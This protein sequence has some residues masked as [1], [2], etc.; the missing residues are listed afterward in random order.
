VSSELDDIRAR[1]ARVADPISVLVGLFA[2]APV[3]FQIYHAN[4]HCLV[5][6][7]AFRDI[8]GGEPSPDY[9]VLEDQQLE[10]GI[11]E[12]TRRVFI[13][14]AFTTPPVW[15]DSRQAPVTNG[16]GRRCAVSCTGFP[17]F[18]ADGRIGHV[19]LMFK[20]LTA[21][22]TAREA[23]QAERD[24]LR[25]TQ[26]RLQAFLDHAPAVVFVKNLEGR[27]QMLSREAERVMGVD[28]ATALGKTARELFGAA[29][30]AL[31][32]AND[33][34]VTDERTPVQAVE[35][36]PTALGIRHFLMTRFPILGADGAVTGSG[37]IA[38]DVS[39]HKQRE[40]LLQKSEQL[41][42][43]VF[44]SLPMPAQLARMSD[45]RFIDVNQAWERLTG[46]TR[47]EHVGR[48][49]L[50]L[51]LW[52]EPLQRT[53]LL[54]KLEPVSSVHEFPARL[55]TRSGTVRE[56][57]LSVELLE[58]GGEACALMLAQDVTEVRRLER[59][60]RHSQQM[61]AVGRLAGG[62]A[63][64]FNNILTA[65]GGANT[66]LLDELGA[67][68]PR[69]RFA[70]QIQRSANRAATL[71]RQLLTFTRKQPLEPTVLDPNDGVRATA[72][73]LPR[74]IGADIELRT[75]LLAR[76]RV[77]AD[78][79]AIE[80]VLLNLAVNARDAMPAGG[81]L[82]LR[83]ADVERRD[84]I[85]EGPEGAWVRITVS[86]TGVGMDAQTRAHLFEPFF[87]TK[88]QGKGTGLGLS[89]VYGTIAQCGGHI[90][91]DSEPGRG[92][93]FEIYLP[94]DEAPLA[95]PPPPPVAE[96]LPGGRETIL[97]VE[98]DDAVRDFVR[99][100]L[101]TLGYHVLEAADGAQALN[102][103]GAYDGRIDLLLSDVVM[104]KMNGV[105]LARRLAQARP[106]I[107]VIHMSGYAGEAVPGGHAPLINKPFE[108]EV[109]A[110]RV[111]A[112]L[113][114][115]G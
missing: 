26:S 19:A 3:G 70:E 96:A 14:E 10:G 57:L 54:A 51:G 9:N 91:V 102:V 42:S 74:M 76:G 60:L 25:E 75:E 111:R 52:A 16:P 44:R 8:F 73:L 97:L 64:D 45:S 55:R 80:Q 1:L 40:E 39:E 32:L 67:S 99:F 113:D 94:R 87:T 88:E 83:T 71:T 109:L 43:R 31:S 38:L 78:P 34:R 36:L 105:E 56:L 28:P 82:T 86:D 63:H 93:T 79:G 95:A 110:R 6:N 37:G 15:Y 61:E 115:A 11:L 5:T 84:P 62:L 17:L 2:H 68:D 27:Y 85:P 69:R 103:A 7:R 24:L 89:T 13:G 114:G 101:S 53:D 46:Y 30:G 58:I 112:T 21:E 104:P 4:G 98:D 90:R 29:Y 108:R 20:E 81:V 65:I 33:R 107:K 48:S 41:F 12:L 49:A 18:D 22:L 50:E 106:A 77:R 35:E 23:V 66:L 92:T 72:E 47:D 100:V 59:E